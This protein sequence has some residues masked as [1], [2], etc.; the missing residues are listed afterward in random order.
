MVIKINFIDWCSVKTNYSKQLLTSLFFVL[1]ILTNS[2]VAYSASKKVDVIGIP[3][4]I[5]LKDFAT[6]VKNCLHQYLCRKKK[7]DSFAFV[8]NF[9]VWGT[10]KFK[11]GSVTLHDGSVLK[12]K[13][14]LLQTTA[15][16]YFQKNFALIIPDGETEAIY[17]GPGYALYITQQTKKGLQTYDMYGDTYLHRLVSG[18]LRLSFNPGA[19][20]SR[21][22]ASFAPGLV[23][24]LQKEVAAHEIMSAIKDGKNLGQVRDGGTASQAL[25]GVVSSITIT[26]KEYLMFDEETQKTT[27]ITKSNHKKIM[28][29]LLSN[30][31]NVDPKEAK[32]QTKSFKKIV[33]A[34]EYINQECG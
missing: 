34:F 20:N 10:P 30:C 32:K 24:R 8:Y 7:G 28:A 13:V 16:W 22:L 21:S 15:T 11:E 29:S 9:Q 5:K 12:G 19:G 26:Q 33:N 1:F 6:N 23:E 2:G 14:A 4:D 18:K 3:S 25:V 17:V 31:P 27:L